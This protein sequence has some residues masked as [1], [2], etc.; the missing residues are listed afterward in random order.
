MDA[1]STAENTAAKQRP[2]ADVYGK[3]NQKK[4]LE[5][6]LRGNHVQDVTWNSVKP[7]KA[8]ENPAPEASKVSRYFH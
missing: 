3:N 8:A 4:H 6:V 2:S 7:L 1:Q 5:V